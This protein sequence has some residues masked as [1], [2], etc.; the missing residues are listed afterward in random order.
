MEE[1]AGSWGAEIPRESH[2]ASGEKE[3]FLLLAHWAEPQ[4]QAK[5]AT[6]IQEIGRRR[7]GALTFAYLHRSAERTGT[8]L[9]YNVE[10]VEKVSLPAYLSTKNIVKPPDKLTEAQTITEA[11]QHILNKKLAQA[12]D[13]LAI[14]FLA[15]G[16]VVRKKDEWWYA[17]QY[18]LS[19]ELI[20]T[21]ANSHV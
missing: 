5:L 10:S 9:L 14:R 21:V 11:L 4:D 20:S 17:R 6:R 18:E 1:K 16:L 7:P 2:G 8:G 12:A 15:L 13:R 19:R 3:G